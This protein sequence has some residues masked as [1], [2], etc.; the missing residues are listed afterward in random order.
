[1]T[2]TCDR[3]RKNRIDIDDI[4]H[5]VTSVCSI[6]TGEMLKKN[7]LVVFIE[8]EMYLVCN[9]AF[10]PSLQNHRIFQFGVAPG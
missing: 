1:M 5:L 4:V 7:T 9:T 6:A 2:L 10:M 3:E 8:L